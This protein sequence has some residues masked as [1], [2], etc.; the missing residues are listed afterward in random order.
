[1]I[2][3]LSALMSFCLAYPQNDNLG[4]MRFLS[5]KLIL[6]GFEPADR[7]DPVLDSPDQSKGIVAASIINLTLLRI[8]SFKHFLP[9][10]VQPI[11]LKQNFCILRC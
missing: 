10:F 6:G 4:E 8:Y 2:L 11:A 9:F 7:E 3:A 5:S 1:L